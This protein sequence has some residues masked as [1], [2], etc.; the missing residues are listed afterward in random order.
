M[1][2]DKTNCEP[3]LFDE[4]NLHMGA[5][6]FVENTLWHMLPKMSGARKVELKWLEELLCRFVERVIDIADMA[7]LSFLERSTDEALDVEWEDIINYFLDQTVKELEQLQSLFY[8]P[9]LFR[10]ADGYSAW[11]AK[12]PI[13]GMESVHDK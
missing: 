13:S 2:P 10:L 12:E 7:L 6:M 1:N 8:Q 9:L 5:D 3:Y 4:M 11:T